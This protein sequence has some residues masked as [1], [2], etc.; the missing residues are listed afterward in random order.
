M[1]FSTTRRKSRDL[2]AQIAHLQSQV[3]LLARDRLT[4]V[5]TNVAGTA[6]DVV[7]RTT[8]AVRD[9][10]R[11]VPD[12]VKEHPVGAILL[13]AALGWLAARVIPR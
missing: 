3:E 4:P 11:L 7:K 1:A 5:V 9:Q 13:A 6:G 12:Q 2:Q 8:G 10:S